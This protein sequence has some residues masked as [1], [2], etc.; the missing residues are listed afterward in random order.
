MKT[1]RIGYTDLY[2]DQ[3][4]KNNVIYNLIKD[5][6]NVE[7]IDTTVP[8]NRDKVEYL[9]YSA[10]G[11]RFLDYNCVRIFVTGEN[12]TPEFNLCDYGIG[13]D[14]ITFE[15]R[16]FRLPIYFWELYKKDFDAL[17]QNRMSLAGPSPEKREF[18]GIVASNNT[19]ADPTRE[20]FFEAL[21]KYKHVA[22]GGRAYNNIGMPDGVPDKTAFLKNYKFS[23]AFENSSYPGYCTEK[24]M[25]AFAAGN[26]PIY[27]G[28]P[29]AVEQFNEKAFINCCGLTLE[30][31]VEKVK[32]VDNNHEL[33]LKM[34]S[35]NPLVDSN[36][37]EKT[38]EEFQKFLFNIFDAEPDKA[39]RIPVRGKMAVYHN[40]YRKLIRR[41]EWLHNNKLTLLVGKLFAKKN[42]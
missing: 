33:Y 25:Q 36:L 16:F 20:N 30:E 39:K 32:E 19:F 31:A 37:K 1:I 11:R 9:I 26:V 8:A 18:C 5:R 41:D 14:H 42:L 10:C 13:F 21:S 6:Y 27:W 38:M 35:E 29:T 7:I 4:P 17:L 24:L 34:L 3:D 23:I 28:D 40:N 22:S 12:L 15:D 2:P